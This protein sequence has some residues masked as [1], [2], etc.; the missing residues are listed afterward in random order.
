MAE[1][2]SEINRASD[3]DFWRKAINKESTKVKI[4]WKTHDGLTPQNAQEGNVPDLIGFQ[5][6]GCHIVFDLKMDFTRRLALLLE[7][8]DDRL[9]CSIT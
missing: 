6:I 8:F 3:T 5:E 9:K 7:V 2:A 1:E 4:A